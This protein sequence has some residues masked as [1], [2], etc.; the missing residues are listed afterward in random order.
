MKKELTAFE[1]Y[2]KRKNNKN[3]KENLELIEDDKT[4]LNEDLLF[5]AFEDKPLIELTY[6]ELLRNRRCARK[7]YRDYMNVVIHQVAIMDKKIRQEKPRTETQIKRI[8]EA[9]DLYDKMQN[10]LTAL[11]YR[12]E[13]AEDAVEAYR[14]KVEQAKISNG[15]R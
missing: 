10:N 4:D 1:V 14:M 6:Q 15:L 9:D 3:E 7:H 13:I 11:E 5:E 12:K 2:E 8:L